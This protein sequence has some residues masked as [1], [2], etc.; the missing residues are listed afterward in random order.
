[1]TLARPNTRSR[2]LSLPPVNCRRGA[3]YTLRPLTVEKIRIGSKSWCRKGDNGYLETGKS[4]DYLIVHLA[5]NYWLSV[6]IHVL[7]SS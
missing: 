4:K 7:L 2:P 6:E 1:M 3:I 5:L